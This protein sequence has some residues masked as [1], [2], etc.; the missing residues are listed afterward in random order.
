MIVCQICLP[1]IYINLWSWPAVKSTIGTVTG[2]RPSGILWG[3]CF[4]A[5]RHIA[6]F[7]AIS[8]NASYALRMDR[9]VSNHSVFTDCGP[10][11]ERLCNTL[12]GV[13][14]IKTIS[15]IVCCYFIH[16]IYCRD[17]LEH[18][19]FPVCL[20][21]HSSR[22]LHV[23]NRYCTHLLTVGERRLSAAMQSYDCEETEL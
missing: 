22:R 8:V 2:D 16:W 10:L 15:R 19:K 14:N 7:G 12:L 4:V 5:R 20:G 13:K 6:Y 18:P 3:H 1:I 17:V 11:G 23:E 21:I 9:I